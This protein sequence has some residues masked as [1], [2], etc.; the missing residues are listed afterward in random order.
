MHGYR[1]GFGLFVLCLTGWGLLGCSPYQM[2]GVVLEGAVSRI[3][4]VAEDDPRLLDGY[5]LPLALIECTLDADRLNRKD[6]PE[7]MTDVDGTFA[8]TVDEAG[9][10]YLEYYVR[11]VVR[12]SGYDTAVQNLR[13]PGPKQRLLITLTR[14]SDSY[15]PDPKDVMEETLE[16][17]EPYMH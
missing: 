2:R 10:G 16:L 9:A 4:V 14:G 13:V 1:R 17:G 6:L 15:K 12:K 3:R 11:V 5:P 7:D 8:I